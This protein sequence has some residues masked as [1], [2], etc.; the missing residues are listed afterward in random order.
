[1][2]GPIDADLQDWAG[3]SSKD[4]PTLLLGNGLSINLWSG[5]RYAS[6][7]ASASLTPE[8][9]AIFAELGTTNFEQCLECLHHAN[10]ALRALHKSTTKVDQTYAEVRDALFE[11]VG[12][13]HVPW[14]HFPQSTHDLLAETMNQHKAVFTTSYDLCLYWSHLQTSKQV[15]MI[16]FFWAAG[17]Q[18]D[19]DNVGVRS[20]NA[21]RVFYLHGGLHLWQDDMTDDN[22]KWTNAD[23]SLLDLRSKYGPTSSRRPLFVSEG[24]SAAKS[25]TIRQS[26]YLT[27]CLEELRNDD[28][29]TVL[30]GQSLADQDSHIAEALNEGGRRRIAIS[31]FPSGDHN[32][33]I[34]EKARILRKL[35]DHNVSFFDSTSHPIGDSSLQIHTP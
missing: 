11:T 15:N 34:A 27:F 28:R 14:G 12:D 18:F 23:G 3:L 24:T 16:D 2:D 20:A 35:P 13:V 9:Q 30:F 33:I 29:P 17:R 10:I 22:G 21:T 5:F 32:A 26:T 7:Y 25:R 4:W 8:A 31:M 19:P 6:L 1:M